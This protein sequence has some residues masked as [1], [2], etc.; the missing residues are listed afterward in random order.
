MHGAAVHRK[1]KFGPF[2]LSSSE[3]VLRRGGE[4]LR[5]GGRALDI[6]IY[7]ADRP[8]EVI[9]KQ[10][11]M[12]R[13]W[14]DVTVEEGSLRVHVAAIRKAL[15]D[16]QFGNRY[17]AN[18]KGRGYS[19][20]GTVVPLTGNTES[21]NDK[22]R[23]QGRLPVRPLMMIDR[24]SVISEVND[25]LRDERFV[26]LIGPGGIGKTTVACAVGRAAAEEFGGEV[27]FVDL[28]G[29]TDPC[30]VAGAVATSLGFALK[31]KDASLEV[32]DLVRSRE[33]LI[34]L[35]SC[36]HVIEAVA[37]LAEQLY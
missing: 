1:L 24:E 16:G 9:A 30:H 17:I 33:L 21:R 5:L 3:R 13:I 37:S 15:G 25:K 8:G 11:L 29:L 34:I 26:T 2:E 14:S 12:D 36:E 19:F 31:S 27:Y 18:I 23:Q 35:D 32:V 4:G 22:F 20:V 6:L 7:L 28:E 10:E